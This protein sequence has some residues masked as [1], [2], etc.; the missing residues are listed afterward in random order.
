MTELWVKRGSVEAA[1]VP[2][3][4]VAVERLSELDVETQVT[5]VSAALCVIDEVRGFGSTAT[6]KLLHRLR[7]NIVPIWD[8]WVKAWYPGADCQR[9]WSAWL[10]QVYANVREPENLACLFTA[11]ASLDERLP[12]Y[13]FGIS[14]CG[15]LPASK[16][17]R[18]T[19]ESL[20]LT[21]LASHWLKL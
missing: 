3:T 15:N 10:R 19:D 5:A 11:R 17:R 18:K 4:K 9:S 12:C 16:R 2:V 6:T 1:I 20:Y 14:S 8:Q 21:G 7:P 13:E